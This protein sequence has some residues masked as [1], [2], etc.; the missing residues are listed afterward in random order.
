MHNQQI[1]RQKFIDYL[2][3]NMKNLH[4]KIRTL[5]KKAPEKI[6]LSLDVANDEQADGQTDGQ[7]DRETDSWID[8]QLDR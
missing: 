8:G 5:S 7:T 4:E 2:L 3:M 6:K 1:D